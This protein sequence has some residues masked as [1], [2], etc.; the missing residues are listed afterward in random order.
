MSKCCVCK[1]ET[2]THKVKSTLSTNE[3]EYCTTCLANK[4]ESYEELVNF[5][6][7]SDIFPLH[8]KRLVVY[9]SLRYYN[10]SVDQFNTDV[11]KKRVERDT[12]V[13]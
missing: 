7:T 9:P 11:E 10:I 6:W 5:G 3:L 12:S 1:A 2:H 13:L 4:Y 8:F